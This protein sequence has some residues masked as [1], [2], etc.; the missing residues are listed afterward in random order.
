MGNK[1]III[2]NELD[3]AANL[4][5]AVCKLG[6][7]EAESIELGTFLSDDYDSKIIDLIPTDI[8]I[9]LELNFFIKE[10]EK[11]QDFIKKKIS[12]ES[13]E[14]AQACKKGE[15]FFTKRT[16]YKMHFCY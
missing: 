8:I 15:A 7:F 10:K 2:N 1:I 6:K 14:I 12:A 16:G 13:A 4:L 9:A 5:D 11:I 3:E